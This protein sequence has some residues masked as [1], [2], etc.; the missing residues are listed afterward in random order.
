MPG[1]GPPSAGHQLRTAGSAVLGLSP[2]PV[3]LLAWPGQ[4][5]R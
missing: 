2:R 3:S 1:A 5:P 4:L